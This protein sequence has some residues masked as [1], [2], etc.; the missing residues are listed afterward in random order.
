MTQLTM[1]DTADWGSR[2]QREPG[3]EQDWRVVTARHTERLTPMA[4]TVDY[5]EG[6][7][8][9]V[10]AASMEIVAGALV[11]RTPSGELSVAFGPGGWLEV[12]RA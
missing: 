11:F 12:T 4:E 2:G 5:S 6:A 7:D 3:A 1:L 9:M 10:R 8:V